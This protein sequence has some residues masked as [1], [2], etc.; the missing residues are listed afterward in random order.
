MDII[1]TDSVC[2]DLKETIEK[3]ILCILHQVNQ[4]DNENYKNNIKF[5]V[6][7]GNEIIPLLQKYFLGQY[8]NNRRKFPIN[9]KTAHLLHRYIKW[10]ESSYKRTFQIAYLYLFGY[11][12]F[13]E[14]SDPLI[15]IC[16]CLKYLDNPTSTKIFDFDILK[17]YHSVFEIIAEIEKNISKIKKNH[18]NI[19]SELNEFVRMMEMFNFLFDKR[20]RNSIAHSDYLVKQDWKVLVRSK[21]VSYTYDVAD[22][23]R[24]Y[25]L[26]YIYLQGYQN[27]I[28][29]FS[30]KLLPGVDISFS[31]GENY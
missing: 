26:A 20:L 3:G 16:N 22:V 29:K 31:W 11:S 21:G 17:K 13:I 23:K 8:Y 6:T 15:L 24:L 19:H 1:N 12:S 27:S 25:D 18:P 5:N 28:D 14:I 2:D 9:L 7:D 30:R 4:I 10:I